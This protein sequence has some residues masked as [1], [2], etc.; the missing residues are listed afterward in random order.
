MIARGPEG[1]PFVSGISSWAQDES[2]GPSTATSLSSELN[3]RAFDAHLNKS[4]PL[5]RAVESSHDW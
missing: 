2:Y 5:V 3:A 4:E 1:E